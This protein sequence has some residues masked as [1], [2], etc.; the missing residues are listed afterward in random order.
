MDAGDHEWQVLVTQVAPG[1]LPQP[2]TDVSLDA[3]HTGCLQVADALTPP[4]PHLQVP[5]L[6]D[7]TGRDTAAGWFARLACGTERLTWGQPA[8]VP[9]RARELD[10]LAR[11]AE[12]A[13]TGSSGVHCDLRADNVLVDDG[14][15]GTCRATFVDWNWLRRGAAWVDFVG[16]L[17]LAHADGLD[18]DAW[19]RSSPLTREV[20]PD[21]VDSF[22]ALIAGMM[23]DGADLPV[24]PG[25]PAL[26]RVHQRRYARTFLDWLAHRRAWG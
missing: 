8:W 23:L 16:L 18:A 17:P 5:L 14:P 7:L 2:W 12:R 25:G 4:P 19:L 15:G 11:G 20:D 10:V 9:E 26:V 13:T 22:L 6:A 1:R 3:V 24:W 21:A